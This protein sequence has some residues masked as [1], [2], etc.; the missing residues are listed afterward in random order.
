M[1]RAKAKTC[2]MINLLGFPGAGSIMA[3]KRMTGYWQILLSTAGALDAAWQVVQICKLFIESFQTPGL[4]PGY[5]GFVV[6][7]ALFLAGWAWSG[8]TSLLV[9]RE[10]EPDAPPVLRE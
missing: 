9:L 7:A 4:Q 2:L 5:G 10:A 1:T 8:W 3:G 6:A